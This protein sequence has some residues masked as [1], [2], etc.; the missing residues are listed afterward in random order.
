LDKGSGDA[1]KKTWIYDAVKLAVDDHHFRS[2]GFRTYGQLGHSQKVLLTRVPD[3]DKK[4][5][6]VE[7]AVDE[8]QTVKQLRESIRA[9]RT[10]EAENSTPKKGFRDWTDPK[11]NVNICT[12]C[13][14][15]CRY[16]YA[17]SMAIRFNRLKN[18]DWG[19]MVVRKADVEK[20]RKRHSGIVGFPSS[21]DIFPFNLDDYL[22]VLGKLLRADNEVLIVSKPRK[23][24]I[25]PICDACRF[26]KD[27]ILFRFTIG[28][29]D[30]AV[31]DF[32]EPHAPT[33]EERKACLKYAYD[34]GFRTSVSM[35]PMLDTVEIE[36]LIARLRPY[37]NRDIWLGTMNHLNAL[38]KDA[39]DTLITEIAKVEAG[40][41]L[42]ML[43]AIYQLFK[44]D[45]QIKWK[46]ETSD[47]IG[48]NKKLVI[49][50]AGNGQTRF[51]TKGGLHIANGYNRV[52]L[53]D[54]GAYVEF[55]PDQMV[56]QNL[57]RPEQNHR[58]FEE[59]RSNDENNVMV[60]DQ[61]RTVAYADYKIGKFY[62]SPL[63]LVCDGKP[64]WDQTD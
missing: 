55:E 12:G 10:P 1:P 30:N 24:C 48:E 7:K 51:E 5:E 49:L 31:L 36:Q 62:I 3:R 19:K 20:N 18:G 14:N 41:S 52:V 58:F 39:D 25:K 42:E 61:K 6:L 43:T 21:H 45:D 46:S 60:Y 54:R 57:I 38:K 40:Q 33:Y 17:K 16:C 53:G 34:A 11:N 13:A 47:F 15:D 59:W 37:V 23:D 4:Q 28:A 44:N 56:H 35:E 32:W 27:K 2:I 29:M 8:G 63:D 22:T 26:F 50:V 64:A 9:I